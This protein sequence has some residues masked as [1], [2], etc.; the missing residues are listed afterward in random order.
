MHVI[1]RPAR[2]NYTLSSPLFLSLF[3]TIYILYL[4]LVHLLLSYYPPLLLSPFLSLNKSLS[5]P[6]LLQHVDLLLFLLAISP[7][8]LDMST[9]LLLGHNIFRLLFPLD[10]ILF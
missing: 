10:V 4:I 3:L 2:E 6:L 7:S 8:A 9:H 1:Y 5:F